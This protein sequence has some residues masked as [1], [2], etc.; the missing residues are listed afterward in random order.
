MRFASLGSGSAGNALVVEA[1]TTRLLLDC[2]L[3]LRE[4]VMR[5]AKL[6]LEPQQLKGILVTHEHDDHASGAFRLAAKHRLPI[7][8][9]HGT[10]RASRR[11]LP[12]NADIQIH[13]ID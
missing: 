7:W 1:G 8:I 12:G 2:G 13:V 5:L 10:L 3:G 6:G 9:T 11:H 4:T